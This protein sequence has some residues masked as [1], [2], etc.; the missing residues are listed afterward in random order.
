MRTSLLDSDGIGF[1]LGATMDKR[2]RLT[3]GKE[4]ERALEARVPATDD[5]DIHAAKERAVA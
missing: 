1:K 3:V 5:R 4:L 2:D